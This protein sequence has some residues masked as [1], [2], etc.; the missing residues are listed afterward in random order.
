M[1]IQNSA[2][3]GDPWMQTLE[4]RLGQRIARQ[5]KAMGITQA[6][7]AERVEVQPETISRIETGKRAAS[8]NKIAEISG[9]LQ[10]K[11]Y[12][13]FFL[14]DAKSPKDQETEKL[15]WF[16]SRLSADEIELLLVVGSA[17][18]DSTRRTKAK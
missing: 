16:V 7:L 9:V 14:L 3:M 11:L 10:L 4:E 1:L 17:V 2:F 6:E 8:V 15:L 12:E 5:R 18:I 13:M